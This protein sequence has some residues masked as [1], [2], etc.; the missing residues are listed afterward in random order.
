M[1][2]KQR[3][4]QRRQ[5][6]LA[7]KQGLLWV[8]AAAA[9]ELL[10][11]LVNR[12]AIDFDATAQGVAVAEG[13]R[14]ALRI[15][16]VLGGV[17]L[18][19]G[20]VLTAMELKKGAKAGWSAAM[21]AGSAVLML[22]AHVAVKYQASGLR[23]L[24]LLVPVL[25][26]LALSYYIYPRDFFVS[27]VPAVLSV[28]GLWFLRVSGVGGEAL[29]TLLVCALAAA[30]VVGLKKNDG[31]FKLGGQSLRVAAEKTNYTIAL[32]SSAAAL[33]VQILAIVA[34][35]TVAYYLIFA[36][37]A[38]LFALLVYYTVKMM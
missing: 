18:L 28:L 14:A 38:W 20:V 24:Y 13:L 23:M 27:A 11:F 37:G 32:V 16:R 26:G 19:A 31:T 4:E 21:A 34:G 22:C 8:A 5:D 17:G 9:A 6:D 12:Y 25:G 2:K 35:G 1:N 3:E 33:A 29:G 10:L 36:M 7:L 30:V 15:A